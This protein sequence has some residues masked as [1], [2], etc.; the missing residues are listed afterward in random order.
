MTA[1]RD[2]YGT[3][4]ESVL[5]TVPYNS[6]TE[7]L[8]WYHKSAPD[9]RHGLACIYQ[10]LYVA[11]RAT[12]LGAPEAKILQDLRH[13]AAVFET[14]GDVVVLDPYLL[15]LTPI[16]FPAREVAAGHS[17]VEVDAAPVRLD[18][19]G[20]RHPGR[21]AAVYRSSDH[22]YRIRLSYSKY[23]VEKDTYIL[24]RHFTLRSENEFVYADFSS[25]ML[26]LL[27]HPEQNSVSIR[28]LVA[29]AEVTAEAIIPLKGFADREFSAADIWLRSG[30]G[31][32]SRNGDG[33]HASAVWADL[34]RST[35][36]GR[37]DIEEHLVSAAQVYQKIADH[38]TDLP[39][40]S[41]QDA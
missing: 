21:L 26:G 29:G 39:G 37:A 27:T 12:A 40:Y 22:G 8:H 7:Y 9:P 4:L 3:A 20:G 17:S 15:H 11:E 28:A 5:R 6:G 16:R 19:R 33:A 31:V 38:R 14:G 1:T 35:G 32:A 13:I 10:T 23:S 34:E 24:S 30:Q 2:P 41:L 25:D 36:L 18:A